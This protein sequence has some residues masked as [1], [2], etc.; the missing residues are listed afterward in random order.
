M[1]NYTQFIQFLSYT[2]IGIQKFYKG[3]QRNYSYKQQQKKNIFCLKYLTTTFK[4][5]FNLLN[6]FCSLFRFFGKM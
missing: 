4:I 1:I 2:L 5:N 6:A 3:I